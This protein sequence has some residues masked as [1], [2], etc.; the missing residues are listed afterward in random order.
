MKQV[1]LITCILVVG[2]WRRCPSIRRR[3]DTRTPNFARALSIA[4]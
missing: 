3:P 4:S 2:G 1:L